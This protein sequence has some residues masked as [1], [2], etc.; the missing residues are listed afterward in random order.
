MELLYSQ[1]CTPCG[2]KAE[3]G[4]CKCRGRRGT[5]CRNAPALCLESHGRLEQ[6]PATR[7]TQALR[8]STLPSS[9]PQSEQPVWLCRG[10]L[11]SSAVRATEALRKSLSSIVDS[12]CTGFNRTSST[13]ITSNNVQGKDRR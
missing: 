8:G 13:A 7:A 11:F 4:S 3:C 1:S 9:H 10:S 6:T 12:Q 5:A 2:R